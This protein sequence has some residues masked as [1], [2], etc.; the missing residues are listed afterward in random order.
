MTK[1]ITLEQ[2]LIHCNSCGAEFPGEVGEWHH[3]ACPECGAAEIISD[4]DMA[5]FRMLMGITGFINGFMGDVKAPQGR[6]LR[7]S[8]GSCHDAAEQQNV[9]R[10]DAASDLHPFTVIY[11]VDVEGSQWQF[12]NCMAEDANHAEDQCIDAEPQATVLWVNEGH[13]VTT[14]E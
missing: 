3:K 4:D 14:M 9:R 8:F 12:F 10:D 7:L 6:G 11:V 5:Q 1:A 13:N 2:T